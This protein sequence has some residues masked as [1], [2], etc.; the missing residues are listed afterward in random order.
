MYRSSAAAL[1]E[2]QTYEA[3]VASPNATPKIKSAPLGVKEERRVRGTGVGCVTVGGDHHMGSATHHAKKNEKKTLA[4]FVQGLD[5]ITPSSSRAQ[6]KK[7]GGGI[8]EKKSIAF[9]NFKVHI[10]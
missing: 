5:D 10:F 1:A 6:A 3:S 7:G 4:I 2:S 9:S 8:F